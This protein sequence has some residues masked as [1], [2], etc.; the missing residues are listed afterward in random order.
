V[1]ARPIYHRHSKGQKKELR[2]LIWFGPSSGSIP[3]PRPFLT[4]GKKKK[5]EAGGA[6]V[7]GHRI[8]TITKKGRRALA[9]GRRPKVRGRKRSKEN[10]RLSA[11]G[12]PVTHPGER[13]GLATQGR[14][15]TYITERG[16]DDG[17]F[18]R[19]VGKKKGAT[20]R[21]GNHLLHG[22]RE[23]QTFT[24]TKPCGGRDDRKKGKS[25]KRDLR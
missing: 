13:K 18:F 16:K 19:L 12:A 7:L 9:D 5:K 8:D 24:S 2:V 25:G 15:H 10:K 22:K 3:S 6:Y 11:T 21:S 4:L 17:V 20:R 1:A 23:N 14:S